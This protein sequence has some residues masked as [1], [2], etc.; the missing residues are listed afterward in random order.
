MLSTT[1]LV[2]GPTKRGFPRGPI[3]RSQR[4]RA[5]DPLATEGRRGTTRAHRARLARGRRYPDLP[6]GRGDEQDTSCDGQASPST[7]HGAGL[8]R[9]AR[10]REPEHDRS[11]AGAPRWDPPPSRPKRGEQARQQDGEGHG[12]HRRQALHVVWGTRQVSRLRSHVHRVVDERDAA[13]DR[14]C[15]EYPTQGGASRLASWPLRSRAGERRARPRD[16][17]DPSAP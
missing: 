7:A 15:E 12:G 11:R 8:I 2:T 10:R 5:M 17:R 14:D 3:A 1:P 4:A 16:P 9:E 13:N 6:L